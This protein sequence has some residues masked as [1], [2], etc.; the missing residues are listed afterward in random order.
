[1]E[2]EAL[3][4]S[5]NAETPATILIAEDDRASRELFAEILEGEGYRIVVARDGA[6]AVDIFIRKPTDLVL[7][8]VKMPHLTGFEV[9]RKIK[10][11]PDTRLIPVVLV[12]GSINAN[13]RIVAIECGAD[14]YLNKPIRKDEFIARI[15]SLLRIKQFTDDLETAERV[16][17]S[18][19]LSIE[20]KDPY[21]EG[22]CARLSKYSVD[23]AAALGLPEEERSAL[24]KAA[25]VHDIGKVA[26]P[27]LIL[28]K[29]G[30][31][32]DEELRIMALHPV[33]GERIC[34]PLRSFSSVLPIIRHHHEKM[35]GSGYPDGLK[36]EAIPITA[37]IMATVDIYDALTTDRPFRSAMPP[38]KAFEIMQEEVGK[39]WLDGKL[40]EQFRAIMAKA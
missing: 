5:T 40:V 4:T 35:D 11:N 17:F 30:G 34:R 8:D 25:V 6:E 27:E 31:L 20:A 9:C 23:L 39:G 7:L 26:V 1:V 37:R 15:R 10:G 21:T 38:E 28:L 36:G 24:R 13:D 33:V 22:H 18:L 14:D 19:A 32:T 29:P 2:G 16:L 3:P 12:S